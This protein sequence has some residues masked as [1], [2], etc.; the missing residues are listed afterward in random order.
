MFRAAGSDCP[1]KKQDSVCPPK[2]QEHGSH[3]APPEETPTK[4]PQQAKLIRKGRG[5]AQGPTRSVGD[6]DRRAGERPNG[7]GAGPEAT[8][9]V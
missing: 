2:R 4:Q 9:R 6:T 3:G 5:L 7:E 8:R 1:R